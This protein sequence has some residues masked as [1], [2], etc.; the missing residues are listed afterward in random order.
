[1]TD[2]LRYIDTDIVGGSSNGTDWANA[3]DGI[4]SWLA[5]EAGV[6]A[7]TDRHIAYFRGTTT[8]AATGQI[9][10]AVSGFTGTAGAELQLI[11]DSQDFPT[12]WDATKYHFQSHTGQSLPFVVDG[13]G[14]LKITLSNLQRKF[15]GSACNSTIYATDAAFFPD[16]DLLHCVDNYIDCTKD[17]RRLIYAS[18][19]ADTTATIVRTG[20]L[21]LGGA[22]RDIDL[23][24]PA[25]MTVTTTKSTL[26]GIVD[27][28]CN[29]DEPSTITYT[30]CVIP[31]LA[32]Y[33]TNQA[34]VLNYCATTNGEGTNAITVAVGDW[35]AQFV[36]R[37]ANDYTF[38]SGS[39]LI[40]TA[41]TPGEN[42]G[43]DQETAEANVDPV[44]DTAFSDATVAAGAVGSV[45]LASNVSDANPGDTL[46]FTVS[47]ALPSGITLSAAGLLAWDGSQVITA[48]ANHTITVSDGNGGTYPTDV[49]AVEVTPLVPTI[50][51][52]DTDNHV[53][54][55]QAAAVISA[56]GIDSSP[57]TQT[58]T[59]G[60]EALTVTDWNSG[61]PIVTIPLHINLQWGQVYQLALTDDTGTTTLNGI[62]LTAP[63]GWT[64]VVYDGTALDEAATESFFEHAKTDVDAGS[65]T[66]VSGDILI[67]ED[68]TG[69]TV[70]TQTLPS[71]DPAATV[72]GGYKIWDVSEATYT[73]LSTYTFTD[74]GAPSVVNVAPVMTAQP[75]ART[76]EEGSAGSVFFHAAASGVPAPTIQ[77]E[78]DARGNGVF[79]E[80]VGATSSPL[81]VSGALLTVAANNG[82]QYRALLTNSEGSVISDVVVLTV[83][84]PGV[85][86]VKKA[87]I[88]GIVGVSGNPVTQLYNHWYITNSD[89]ED[90][91]KAGVAVTVAG[92]GTALQVT[93]GAGEVLTPDAVVAGE[94]TL[95]AYTDDKTHVMRSTVTIIEV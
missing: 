90:R 48:S 66:M 22:N 11:G 83:T 52:I 41:S 50:N 88:T 92:A 81:T 86:L 39:V 46:T 10:F 89:I 3:Y 72:T 70:D 67:F 12:K 34:T 57:S 93:T 80:I 5:A 23:N 69:L 38:A 15:D 8:D 65:F 71:V 73:G 19:T 62:T 2:T 54:A 16:M 94:Y 30:D 4:E 25:G 76:I 47:P 55:G 87:L 6:I 84:A 45:S 95:E 36:D 79:T 59:L 14:D 18:G 24:Y 61:D 27:R 75:A 20:H 85:V 53:L 13:V 32:S 68:A 40:G 60:G 91:N 63:A 26:D 64:Q 9:S 35:N 29:I 21:L 17:T 28:L 44:I 43:S 42:I 49:I 56:I 37:A 82:D 77:W 7:A 58:I 33:G 74:D 31:D 78:K 51:S 1:M